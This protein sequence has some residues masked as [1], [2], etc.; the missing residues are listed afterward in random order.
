V[1]EKY[2]TRTVLKDYIDNN[3][4]KMTFIAERTGITKD[5]LSRIFQKERRLT[6]D[7]FLAI[8]EVL[9]VDVNELMEREEAK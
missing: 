6:A 5:R 2:D 9:K 8:T 7:E 4:I 1:V 3:G